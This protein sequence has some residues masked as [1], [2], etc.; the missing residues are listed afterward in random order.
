MSTHHGV[1]RDVTER[2]LAKIAR[3]QADEHSRHFRALFEGA[4]SCHLALSTD[5]FRIMEV[6]DAYLKATMTTR[7][8]IVGRRLF[9]VFPDN[10][11][12]PTADGVKNIRASLERVKITGQTDVMAVQRYPIRRP[13]AEGGAFEERFW[14]PVSCPLFGA[15]GKLCRIIHRIEDVTEYVRRKSQAGGNGVRESREEQLE[16][17]IVLRSQELK[18][19]Y[20]QQAQSQAILRIAGQVAKVGGWVYSVAAQTLTWSDETAAIHEEPDGFSPSLENAL[21]YHAPEDR[22]RIG[23]MF[24]ACLLQGTSFDVE[25]Q[26]TTARGRRVWVRSIGE[27]ARDASGEITHVQGAFLDLSDQKASE[28]KIHT[29]ARRLVDTLDSLGDAFFTVDREWRFTYL[30]TEAERLLH[31]TRGDLLGRNLWEEF[32]EAVGTT[33]DHEYRRAIAEGVTVSFEQFYPPLNRWLEAQ[34]HPSREGLA[35]YFRDVTERREN[36]EALRESE[37]RLRE[38]AALLDKANDAILVRDLDHHILYWNRSAERLYG[39]TA[40]EAM[41]RSIKDLLYTDPTSFEIATETTLLK[42]EWAGELEQTTKDRQVLIIEGH[43]TLVR[44]DH[45][46]PKSILAINTDI[47]Q[48]KKLEGQFLRAQR[49]ESLGALAGGIAHDLNNALA[50]VLMLI[51]SMREVERDLTLHED[52]CTVESCVQRAADMVRQLLTFARGDD[53]RRG[54]IDLR[55]IGLE[56]QK[57]VTDTF[58]K[59]ITFRMNLPS[60]VWKVNVDATQI[61][62]V[63]TNLCVNARDAMPQGGILNVTIEQVVLDEIYAGMNLEARPGPYVLLRVEDSGVGMPPGVLDRIFEPFFTTKETGRGTGLGLSTAHAIVRNH[64]GFIH[65]YSEV[66]TG[67]RFEVYLPADVSAR[68]S[69][70]AA[71][72]LSTLPRGNG[73]LVLVI[74]DEEAIRTVASRTLERYGYRA[75]LACNGAEAISLYVQHRGEIAVVLTDMAMP[76]MDGPATIVAL[77]SLNPKVRIIGSSGLNANGHVAKA[78]GAG[79]QHFVP[80]PYTAETMLKV[81]KKILSEPTDGD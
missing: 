61:H 77:K 70:E 50:P 76:V 58:P 36:R 7:E 38:Q 9:D 53:G 49:M 65:V 25:T 32:K 44:D 71:I 73:Q 35:V 11:E 34:A 30:N 21:N 72:E 54:K 1:E 17:D 62:Q 78:A 81:L 43:W 41:G 57:I 79:V 51:S 42:G 37:S 75:L 74:D 33:S 16:I 19:A 45:G 47:T 12:D 8:S 29:L 26:M 22:E 20:E 39:W 4:P 66:G 59:D 13:T 28:E 60:T 14:S 64:G 68:T 27:A 6:S 2:R 48:R 80:K 40:A 31:R 23:R 69:E 15:R 56:I 46:A 10:P 63:L 52:L 24:N 18:R 55:K 67:T 5:E 3:R